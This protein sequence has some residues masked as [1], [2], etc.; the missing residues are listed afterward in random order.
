VHLGNLSFAVYVLHLPVMTL[1]MWTSI[2]AVAGGGVAAAAYG[3]TL[4]ALA[5]LAWRAVEVPCR[6]AITSAYDRYASRRARVAERL[7]AP[8]R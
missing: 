8:Q 6:H 5:H 4:L 3:V 2:I 7:P 1:G